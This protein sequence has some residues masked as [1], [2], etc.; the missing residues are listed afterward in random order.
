M[1]GLVLALTLHSHLFPIAFLDLL[2][3]Q[4]QQVKM[5]CYVCYHV[6]FYFEFCKSERMVDDRDKG[7]SPGAYDIATDMIMVKHF[8]FK[9]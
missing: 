6:V 9:A 2:H 3:L 5:I 7:P 4:H 8:Q 1:V